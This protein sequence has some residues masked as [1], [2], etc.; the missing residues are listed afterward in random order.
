MW[1]FGPLAVVSTTPFAPVSEAPNESS[2]NTFG[3]QDL[4]ISVDGKISVMNI[5]LKGS[6]TTPEQIRNSLSGSGQVSGYLY[7]AV[8]AGSLGFASFATGVGSIFSTEMGLASAMLAGFI[9]RQ[10]PVTG[11]LVLSGNT[12]T[13]KNQTVQGQNAVAQITSQNSITAAT[14]DTTISLDTGQRGPAD[15]VVTVKGPI[16]SPTMST[17]GGN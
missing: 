9:N 10:S 6:G 1:N 5:A 8:A 17:R 11:Q 12:V 14:T 15:Y 3:N 4:M 2:T 16:S 7:P 13:L